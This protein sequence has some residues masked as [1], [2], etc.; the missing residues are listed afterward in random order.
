MSVNSMIN[1][2]VFPWKQSFSIKHTNIKA[3]NEF[4][5]TAFDLLIILVFIGFILL[6][7]NINLYKAYVGEDGIVEW[8]TVIVL[9]FSANISFKRIIRLRSQRNIRFLL[10]LLL[11]ALLFCFGVGEEISWGQRIFGIESPDFFMNNNAQQE[12]NIHNLV[13]QNKKI[14][15]VV[16]SLFL[17]IIISLYL[18][19]LPVLY[20]KKTNV[21]NFINSIAIPIPCNYHIISY[22]VF[23]LLIN[24]IPNSD[25]WELLEMVGSFMFFLII[26]NPL[27]RE[28][29]ITGKEG[30]SC[31]R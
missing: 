14:N 9:F 23:A 18:L 3:P 22:I 27:N 19:V 8:L 13:Y 6:Y 31:Y 10:F 21:K 17:G 30:G 16:F 24:A 25:K 2:H 1:N 29:F 4:E 26:L 28:I 12:T 20:K 7:T 15:K 11:T 5:Q